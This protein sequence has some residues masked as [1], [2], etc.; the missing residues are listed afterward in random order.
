MD[1]IEDSF[2]NMMKLVHTLGDKIKKSN[3]ELYQKRFDLTVQDAI[4]Y[5]TEK[6]KNIKFDD[7]QFQF[8]KNSPLEHYWNYQMWVYEEYEGVDFSKQGLI[9]YQ[10]EKSFSGGN[11]CI[12]KGYITIVDKMAT[13]LD[14]R[15]EQVVTSISDYEMNKDK[16]YISITTNNN[17]TYLGKK[18]LIT[19]PLGVLK[20]G[21]IE[22]T[23]Q[24]PDYKLKAIN[25][26]EMGLMNKVAIQFKKRFWDKR[27]KRI[28]YVSEN[29]GEYP[30]IEVVD[31]E[32]AVIFCW[33]ACSSAERIELQT[34]KEILDNI[35]T[36][37]K[38]IYKNEP[39]EIKDYYIT[40]WKQDIYSR[41]SWSGKD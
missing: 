33:L 20:S 32:K 15:L 27:L 12:D 24:L 23:P 17:K 6:K 3:H 31:N 4:D 30:W 41:G 8:P 35:L 37:L 16:D 22:F 19:I 38:Q 29:K 10:K 2:D 36:I 1:S 11:L 7:Y 26:L 14:I 18:V 13:N 28:V 39:M 9:T 25:D 21:M 40:R 34:D 5:I